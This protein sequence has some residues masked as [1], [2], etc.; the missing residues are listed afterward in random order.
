MLEA[1]QLLDYLVCTSSSF[2]RLRVA[3]HDCENHFAM[4]Q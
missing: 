3:T 1:L 4:V 2:H